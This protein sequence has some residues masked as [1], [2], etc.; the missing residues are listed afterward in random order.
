M[1]IINTLNKF[2]IKNINLKLTITSNFL[3]SINLC[4]L[5]IQNSY[6]SLTTIFSNNGNVLKTDII[7]HNYYMTVRI[8]FPY[9]MTASSQANLHVEQMKLK[10]DC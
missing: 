3:G 4:I 8:M 7:D 2:T 1:L 10:I 9:I 6:V 5:H